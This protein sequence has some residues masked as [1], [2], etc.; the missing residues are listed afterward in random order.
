MEG[1]RACS[2]ICAKTRDFYPRPHMEG[3]QRR[4]ALIF[5]LWCISTHAL[6]W[7]AT[8]TIRD[9]LS[10]LVFLPTPSHGGRQDSLACLGAIEISTHALTWRAT[11]V[12]DD[13]C[14]LHAYFYPR[15]HMEGDPNNGGVIIMAKNFYPRPH[16]EG[17]LTVFAPLLCVSKISTHALT[18]RATHH[19]AGIY[20]I[21]VI[22]THALT[23]RATCRVGDTL[24]YIG[25]F[26]PRPHME[27]DMRKMPQQDAP[28]NF[29]PRPHMEGDHL[30][31]SFP[32]LP[33]NFYPRPHMEGDQKAAFSRCP[34]R[35]STHALTWRATSNIGSLKLVL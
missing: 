12:C 6:T 2:A 27:G 7:R 35:I 30:A 22:S 29:Y 17:D 9:T 28:G 3:D 15:P 31:H 20:A 23:W 1:D 16:M 8:L 5:L 34:C 4:T 14:S 19:R 10:E 18:W 24:Y 32:A 26:Y 25:D 13:C 33:D 21:S 11:Q